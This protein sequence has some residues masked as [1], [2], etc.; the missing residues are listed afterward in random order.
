MSLLQ[1]QKQPVLKPTMNYGLPEVSAQ[2]FKPHMGKVRL[3]DV[4]TPGEF[5]EGHIP[6]A[7]LIPLGPEVF[8]FLGNGDR[9]QE[10]VFVCRSGNRSGQ[11]TQLA[12]QWGYKYVVNLE[13]GMIDWSQLGYPL[14]RANK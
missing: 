8:Q 14:E 5:Y 13:G 1:N 9:N 11:V 6:G 7:E 10:I 12:I 2:E 4:R 3:V